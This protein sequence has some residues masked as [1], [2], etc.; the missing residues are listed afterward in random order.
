MRVLYMEDEPIQLELTARWLSA[1]G[2][3]V[4]AVANGLAAISALE[5]DTFDMVILDWNVPGASGQDLLNWIRE[6]G[7]EFPVVF[8]T[9]CNGEFEAAAILQLGADD[10]IVKPFRR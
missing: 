8:A 9:A 10:Y 1:N 7:L 2:H 4:V 5:R 6:R 3:I